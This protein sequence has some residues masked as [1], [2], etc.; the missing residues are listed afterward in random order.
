M[1]SLTHIVLGAAIGEVTLG[2]KVGNK[3]VLWGALIGT[4]P[5]FDVFIT[6]F[7]KPDNALFFHR[8]ISHSL[9][10]TVLLIP[11]LGFI[12]SKI[13]KRQKVE[14]KSWILLA[15]FPLL[16][17]IF[18]DCFN[19]YGT[20]IFEPFSNL[21]IAYDSMA[22]IDILFILPLLTFVLFV[23]FIPYQNRTRRIFAWVS[24]CISFLIFSFSIVN[25]EII[26]SRAINQLQT[27]NLSYN[28]IIT[29]PAPLS[30]FVW[31]I[32]AEDES[33]YNFG[34]ITNF[35]KTEKI[36]FRYIP[37]NTELLGHLKDSKEIGNLIRFSKGFYTVEKDSLGNLWMYDLRYIGLDFDDEKSYVFSFGLKEVQGKVQV[38]RSHPER[39][40]NLRTITKYFNRIF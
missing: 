9:L 11:L 30:N 24:L 23:F 1:D 4:I 37:R 39:R 33:G 31:A 16:S 3:A 8:G 27:Q 36:N 6:P 15:S 19:T 22:I 26:T 18:I 21:R 2:K 25:K 29:T 17:H 12:L 35:D 32:I 5:D 13:E 7:L 34:Y 38:T 10:A 40:I 20:G 28:R 14:L